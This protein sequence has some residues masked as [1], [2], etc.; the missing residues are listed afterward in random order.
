[1][2]EQLM[3]KRM[4]FG[5]MLITVAI[6]GVLSLAGLVPP[7]K[8]QLSGLLSQGVTMT[9]TTT[10]NGRTSTATHYFSGNASKSV[11]ADGN[12]S[13]IRFDQ[14]KLITID[15]KQKTYTEMTFQQMQEMADQLGKSMG[16]ISD[17]PEAAA[18]IKKM[19]GGGNSGP[20]T[21]TKQG[22]GEPVAGYATEKYLVTGP[23]DMQIWAAPDLKV[24][25][26]YYDAVKIRIPANPMFDVGKMYDA[27]KQISGWPVKYV[28]TINMMSRSM[29]TTTEVT[30][31]QK[32]AIPAS[33]FEIPAG[34]KK[35]ESKF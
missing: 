29:T 25:A 16:G 19:M 35:V 20:L 34:Y 8:A 1:M 22:P 13:I 24:P 12:E 5:A 9:M 14:Q 26:T 11:S 21:V 18:A 3:K 23:M 15:N 32:G 28:M 7:A 10:S 30:S 27:F 2:K 4:C 33:T 31:I 6:M 17:N